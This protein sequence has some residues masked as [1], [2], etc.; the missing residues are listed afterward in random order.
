MARSMGLLAVPDSSLPAMQTRRRPGYQR[1]EPAMWLV[2]RDPGLVDVSQKTALSRLLV[3]S[4]PF[5]DGRPLTFLSIVP[6]TSASVKSAPATSAPVKS[7]PERF[8]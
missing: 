3:L 4:I 7:A 6:S 8:T 1:A 5:A 2:E